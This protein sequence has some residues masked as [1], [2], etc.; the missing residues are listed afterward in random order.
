LPHPEAVGY[1]RERAMTKRILGALGLCLVGAA[2]SGLLLLQHHG[3]PRA[4]RA[5]EQVC[6]DGAS[7]CEA[8][9]RSPYSSVAGRP[10]AA[11]GILFYASLA[12][13][14]VL[15]A[16]APGATRDALTGAAFLVLAAG[17]LV[18]LAL[19]GVL[20]FLVGAWCTLCLATYVA[21]A[22]ALALLWPARRAAQSLGPALER[23]EGRL[24]LV[25][26]SLGT[27][28]LAGAVVAA[29]WALDLR[30]ARRQ[31]SLLG[32]P[33]PP[34]VP[35]AAA[36]DAPGVSASFPDPAAESDARHWKELAE[37]LQATLDDPQKLDQYFAEKAQREF[38]AARPVRID[39]EGVPLKGPVGAPVTVVEYS[40]FL[41]PF[42]RN[43][44][45]A[46]TQFVP[47]AGGRVAVY[48]KNYPLD[49]ECN[50]KL[51]S[52][53]HPGACRL[54]LGAICAHYQGKFDAYH[55]RAF[56]VE[57]KNPQNADV[58]RVAAEAGLNAAAMDGCL[59]DPRT[60]DVLRAQIEEGMRFGVR[61]TPTLFVNGKRLP[62]IND[63]LPVVDS[64]AQRKGFKPLAA[65]A[66]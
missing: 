45:G 41:C 47:Q 63:F 5:V 8:V 29:E 4:S 7:G 56:S 51:P 40:D 9:A 1:S 13:L 59:T 65:E 46:L 66:R 31:A 44:A 6:G 42:C 11:W 43:L 57:L 62:R 49:K 23:A 3:E 52:S 28:A 12:L 19:L 18:D 64:E 35:G 15:A 55:D 39:L 38:E 17:L 53:T 61:A 50:P 2:L 48:F 25:G 24:G 30:E 32:A 27:L 36:P 33:A 10:L 20:A 60:M 26:W 54:A 21:T 58:V 22:G 37:R 14:L 16:F 34:P